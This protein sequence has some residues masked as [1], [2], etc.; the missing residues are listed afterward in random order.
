MTQK[1]SAEFQASIMDLYHSGASASQLSADYNVSVQTI[2]KWAAKTKAAPSKSYTE[3]D[4]KALEQRALQ[5][6]TEVEILKKALAIFG[7]KDR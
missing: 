1:F 4:I 5:A 2:Y 6:E 3:S 7:R